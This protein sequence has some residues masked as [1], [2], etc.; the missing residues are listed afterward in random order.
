ELVEQHRVHCFVAD[1]HHFSVLVS[2]HRIRIHLRHFLSNQSELRDGIGIKLLLVAKA[3]GLEGKYCFARFLHRFDRFLKPGRGHNRA[4][5]AIRADNTTYPTRHSLAIDASNKSLLLSA[6][7]A[8]PD[9]GWIRQPRRARW[10]ADHDIVAAGSEI[11][12]GIRA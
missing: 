9:C 5:L 11:D 4:E 6:R 3:H 8:N 12:T 7:L 1:R 2:D 10:R